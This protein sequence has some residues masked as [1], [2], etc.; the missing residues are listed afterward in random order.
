MKK[1]IFLTVSVIVALALQ[2]PARAQE[3]DVRT[4]LLKALELQLSVVERLGRSDLVATLDEA[5]E[6]VLVANDA[7]LG[8]FVGAIDEIQDYSGALQMLDAAIQEAAAVGG[9][10]SART[11]SVVSNGTVPPPVLTPPPYFDGGA[12]GIFCRLPDAT[13]G[14]RTNTEAV[15]IAKIALSAAKVV[16]TAAEVACGLDVVQVG[17]VGIGFFGCAGY[18]AVVGTAEAVVEGFEMCDATIDEA[19]LDA[20]F[21][22]AEDNFILGTHTHEDLA[23]HDRNI[24][25]ELA[26]HDAEVKALLATLQISVDENQEK[27]DEIINVLLTHQGRRD[28]FPQK[29]DKQLKFPKKR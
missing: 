12:A 4:E 16:W 28:G 20:A 11:L 7:D 15:V 21:F 22:R 14:V 10:Q 1:Y 25:A 3:N 18:A 6:Q 26:A 27:L 24:D 13:I 9:A 8:P 29:E 17:T 2:S 23:T 19:H 5:I